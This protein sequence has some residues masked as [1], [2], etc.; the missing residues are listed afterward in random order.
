MIRCIF[1]CATLC[2][3]AQLLAIA[4]GNLPHFMLSRFVMNYMI[5]YCFAVTTGTLVPSEQ[6]GLW[7]VKTLHCPKG[8]P[9]KIVMLLAINLIYTAILASVMTFFNVIILMHLPFNVFLSSLL[10]DFIPMWL[11]STLVSSVVERL[12]SRI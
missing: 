10:V 5:A 3:T 12:L 1:T 7:C 6:F 4:H 11:I 8:L 2:T 9:T